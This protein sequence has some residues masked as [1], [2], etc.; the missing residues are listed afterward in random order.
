MTVYAVTSV[1]AANP[2]RQQRPVVLDKRSSSTS[3]G[4]AWVVIT[5][6]GHVGAVNTIL[7]EATTR[8]GAQVTMVNNDPA[9]VQAAG[10][11]RREYQ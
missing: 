8:G 7:A 2:Q 6:R 1:D 4:S 10:G 3:R 11:S 9:S 5:G